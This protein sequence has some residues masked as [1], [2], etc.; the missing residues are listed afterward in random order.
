M[1]NATWILNTFMGIIIV[2]GGLFSY[3]Q[4]NQFILNHE[5]IERGKLLSAMC[6]ER[7]S[8]SYFARCNALHDGAACT[9]ESQAAL[10]VWYDEFDLECSKDEPPKTFRFPVPEPEEQVIASID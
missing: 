1:V 6:K 4:V 3:N 9:H 7:P 10:Q 5:N 8:Y 2:I